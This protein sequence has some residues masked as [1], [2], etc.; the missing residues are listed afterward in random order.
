[1]QKW[2]CNLIHCPVLLPNYLLIHV[3]IAD[4]VWIL[5]ATSEAIAA[6]DVKSDL[7]FEISDPNYLLIHVHIAYM[8]WALLTASEATTASKQ[9]RRSNL[10]SD[11]KSVT[12]F[13]YVPMSLSDLYQPP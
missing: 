6:S 8:V 4:M 10:T 12:S 5:L 2:L 1:M 7:S 13:T 9:P 3:H 11:F